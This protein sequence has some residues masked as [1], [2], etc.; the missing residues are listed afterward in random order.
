MKIK[1][2]LLLFVLF[3]FDLRAQ[4]NQKYFE[5]VG[6]D[7]KHYQAWF[8]FPEQDPACQLYGIFGS[9]EDGLFM[10]TSLEE[11]ERESYMLYLPQYIPVAVF[12]KAN[13]LHCFRIGEGFSLNKLV[14]LEEKEAPFQW[15]YESLFSEKK[16][17]PVAIELG[18]LDDMDRPN[19][20]TWI[21]GQNVVA[22][23]LERSI[24][25]VVQD[26]LMTLIHSD[27][28]T[29][30]TTPLAIEI[31]SGTERSY[32]VFP[33][34]VSKEKFTFLCREDK[35]ICGRDMDE[36]YEKYIH[37]NSLTGKEIKFTKVIGDK[38]DKCLEL[39]KKSYEDLMN[40]DRFIYMAEGMDVF[41]TD[42]Y[43]LLKDEVVFVY[44][45]GE[46]APPLESI[47]YLKVS[48][49]ALR[50]I[51]VEVDEL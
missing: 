22:S 47:V 1:I 28:L 41:I 30:R 34:R 9:M 19:C 3:V 8:V 51:G 14:D 6:T 25:K 32:S 49:E 4:T 46:I 29:K 43:F 50:E 37:F 24:L 11:K 15:Y 42:N 45:A 23:T 7:G 10:S 33:C 20:R 31:E 26:S 36:Y 39:L 12:W 5:G 40:S 44:Q 17:D 18:G 35:T 21:H 16:D 48:K 2:L 13:T 38:A 27:F